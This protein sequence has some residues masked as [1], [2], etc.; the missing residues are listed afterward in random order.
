VT[1]RLPALA[2]AGTAGVV[3]VALALHVLMLVGVGISAEAGHHPAASGATAAVAHGQNAD[4]AVRTPPAHAGHAH[5]LAECMALVAV[6][7]LAL[8]IARARRTP[9][10]RGHQPPAQRWPVGHLLLGRESAP[11]GP[12]VARGVLLRV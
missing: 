4:A 1:A 12:L 9:P 11:P 7:G 8:L 3:I 6:L 5:L 2:G 10:H